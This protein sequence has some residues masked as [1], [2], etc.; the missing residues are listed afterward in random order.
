M[1]MGLKYWIE[2]WL[3]QQKTRVRR[4]SGGTGG[5]IRGMATAAVATAPLKQPLAAAL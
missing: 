3:G 5:Q 4:L 1:D 2:Y